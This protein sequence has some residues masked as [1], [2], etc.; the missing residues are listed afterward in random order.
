MVFVLYLFSIVL[1]VQSSLYVILQ[2]LLVAAICGQFLFDIKTQSPC[3][4]IQAIH[5]KDKCWILVTH[6]KAEL[7]Y[8]DARIVIHNP[9]FQTIQFLN[10]QKNKILILFNDQIPKPH[11]QILHL[12][13][14]IISI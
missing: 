8:D 9:L 3:P 14:K 2:T 7:K 11:L 4:N 10:P 5:Y 1:I 6:D 12:K 13:T